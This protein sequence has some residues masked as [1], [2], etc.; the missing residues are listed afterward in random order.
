MVVVLADSQNHLVL[1]K[2]SFRVKLIIYKE[3]GRILLAGIWIY[4]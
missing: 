3:G 1:S 2:A 4:I